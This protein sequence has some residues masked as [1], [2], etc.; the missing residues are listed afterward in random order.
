MSKVVNAPSRRAFAEFSGG[1][2]FEFGGHLIDL[3]IGLLGRPQQVSSYL[4]HVAPV[5]DHL[6]DN[7]LAVLVYPQALVTVKTSALEVEGNERRHI[8]VCGS[9]G[10]CHVQPLDAPNVKLALAKPRG[11]YQKAYQE[12]G[13]GEYPRY[14][15]DLADLARIIRGEKEPDFSYDHDWPCSKPR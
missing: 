3:V 13:F 14:V 15:G 1:A 5:D 7:T 8:V 10:T 4:Q 6:A 11:E 12:I 2:M 9:E